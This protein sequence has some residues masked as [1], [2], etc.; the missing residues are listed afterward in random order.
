M[1]TSISSAFM[2]VN[3]HVPFAYK[4]FS[5]TVSVQIGAESQDSIEFEICDYVDC[6]FM[7]NPV[8]FKKASE[9]FTS[10]LGVNLSELIDNEV[11]AGLNKGVLHRLATNSIS[12]LAEMFDCFKK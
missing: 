9:S 12:Q 10:L 6:K 4:G 3:V 8:D 1:K 5:C 11:S 2:F 7:D